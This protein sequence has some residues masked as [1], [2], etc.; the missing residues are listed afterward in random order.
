M[1]TSNW[2]DFLKDWTPTTQEQTPK[3]PY[4]IKVGDI[5]CMQWGYEANNVN[6]FKVLK[7]TKSQVQLGELIAER[8][9]GDTGIYMGV[10]VQPSNTWKHYSLW[11]QDEHGSMAKGDGSEPI[12]LT[13]KI[14]KQVPDRISDGDEFVIVESSYGYAYEWNGKPQTDYNHH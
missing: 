13:R 11:K 5:L 2:A 1:T 9:E 4:V 3:T 8:V 10:Y 12:V 7:R 6:Y 14:R